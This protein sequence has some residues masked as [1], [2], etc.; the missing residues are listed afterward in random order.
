MHSHQNIFQNRHLAKY[1]DILKGPCHSF[2]TVRRGVQLCNVLTKKMHRAACRCSESGYGI[3]EGSL[4]RPIGSK[5]SEYAVIGDGQT[6]I[7]KG[8]QPLKAD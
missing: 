6:D 7:V 8:F 1:S 2:L 3:E 5:E 4:A